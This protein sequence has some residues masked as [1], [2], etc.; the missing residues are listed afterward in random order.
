MLLVLV[1]AARFHGGS[2][3]L[4]SVEVRAWDWLG[5]AGSSTWRAR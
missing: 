3:R 4:R 2:K 1:R 5:R